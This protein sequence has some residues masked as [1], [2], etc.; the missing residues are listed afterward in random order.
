LA[1]VRRLR[2]GLRHH[3]VVDVQD[4]VSLDG[5][6]QVGRHEYEIRRELEVIATVSERWFRVPQTH[7]VEIALDEDDAMILAATIAI[8]A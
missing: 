6:G 2:A 5:H 3:F 4:G 8:E 7:G 1:T